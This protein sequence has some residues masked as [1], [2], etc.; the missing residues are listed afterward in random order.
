MVAMMECEESAMMES[1]PTDTPSS[2]T[3]DLAQDGKGAGGSSG[4]SGSTKNNGSTDPNLRTFLEYFAGA[5]ELSPKDRTDPAQIVL[6]RLQEKPLSSLIW[7][8]KLPGV[9][10]IVDGESEDAVELMGKYIQKRQKVVCLL[11]SNRAQC[12]KNPATLEHCALYFAL[13]SHLDLLVNNE[14]TKL[15]A[16]Q[17]KS[18]LS[19]FK[20]QPHLVGI[21]SPLPNPDD[22]VR[23]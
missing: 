22:T 1:S 20:K 7:F 13:P 8:F 5:E 14:S 2:P 19:Q 3:T 17:A 16:Q 11:L 15:L 23:S 12:D 18:K 10:G 21:L 9:G 4:N 6:Y